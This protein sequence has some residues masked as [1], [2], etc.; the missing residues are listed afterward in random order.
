MEAV[1]SGALLDVLVA[2][3]R[4]A[5][6]VTHLRRT[7]PRE[8]RSADWPAW[9]DPAVVAGYRALG[10]D[11]P[12]THQ[13]EAAEHARA[14]RH[15]VLATSTGSGKSLAFWLPALT[16][17]RA[18][19]TPPPAATSG[20]IETVGRRATTLYLCPTKALA[21]D[22][23]SAL[24]R[25]LG[26]GAVTDVRVA[27][28]DGDTPREERRWVADHADV[29]LTNPDF[30]HFALLPQHRRWARLLGSLRYVVLD[31]C[32]AFRGV[33]GAH[34]ALVLRRLRR[35]A[36]SYG[37]APTVLLASATTAD[38]AVS[39]ARLVGVEP[40]EVAA[41]TADG[42]PT[43]SRTMVLW[44]PPAKEGT[45]RDGSAPWASLLPE[46]DPWSGDHPRRT[47]TAEV[48]DLL[49]DLTSAGA[50]TLAF[51]RSRRAAESVAAATRAHLAEVDPALPATVAAYRGGYLPEER[52][53]LEAAVRT[54]RI[55]ALATTNALELGVD[56]SGLDAVLLAG[57]PGTRVSLWQ[58]A[59]RAGRAGAD[60]LVAL[61]AREDPLDTYLVTHPEAVLDAPVEATVFDPGNPYVLAPH[62]CA[63]AQE[64][65][66]RS[67][68]LDL[69]GP[70]AAGLLDVLVAQGA[71]RRR[72][73][74]WYWTHAEQAARLTDLRGTG[75]DPVRVIEAAT[76]RVLGTVDAASADAQVHDG[77]VYVHQG[78]SFVV[79]RLELA[80]AVALVTRRDV[81][82]GTWA[83]WVTT[84]EVV[85]TARSTSWGPVTWSFG[86]VD[87]TTQVLGYQRKRIPDLQ[88]VGG[89]DLDLPARTLRTAS[90]WWS[91]PAE[92]LLEAGVTVELTPGALHAAEH[93][94]I[95]VLPLLATCDRW[96]LGGLSTALHA[97][98]GRATVFV[99]DAFPGGAGFAERGYELAERWLTAT[100]DVLATCPC[101]SGCPACVQSPKCGNG[102]DPLEKAAA[103]R[104]LD[105]VL[106]HVPGPPDGDLEDAEGAEEP[107]AVP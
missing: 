85:E 26:A 32:H 58:Q 54:G 83:R 59:G 14:G 35:L 96:D 30:L 84:T 90:V 49:A 47:A 80:D 15:T 5:D 2:H 78:E 10:V 22:Q 102:N 74:G 70:R 100:R 79:E 24:D 31:E 28:C 81:D 42:S 93:C 65:P 89:D 34:V 64:L 61:V 13:V 87:V 50:R 77:A 43:G 94:A 76:G 36:A 53:A 68:E 62:L 66:V 69:F 23:L 101:P 18:A 60:G 41:V 8:G 52:R 20:R 71:L 73:S 48:A 4:R 55:R 3:G 27:T 9:S 75:G 51:T 86:M 12:W 44:Q 17:A 91:V 38:P 1:E 92:V 57:W 56:I 98:T 72:A 97:D 21:A 82:Y 67:E 29:V 33:F 46:E 105:V 7:E 25:L 104:L 95:G 106:A 16:A 6:R 63:A 103:L 40:D 11:R 88:V 19:V 99:H 107:L 37:A 39:A 45:G